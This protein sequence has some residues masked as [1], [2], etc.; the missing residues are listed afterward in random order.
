VLHIGLNK[1]G[2][3]S[4]QR[5][6]G[7]NRREL[8][9]RGF[10][11]PAITEGTVPQNLHRLG[12]GVRIDRFWEE[13]AIEI[14]AVPQDGST[15]ILSAE[16]CARALRDP[17]EVAALH[18]R[19]ADHFTNIRI[20]LYLRRQDQHAA[21]MFAQ[22][23]RTGHVA[24]PDLAAIGES[25]APLHDYNALLT[26]WAAVFGEAAMIPRIYARDCLPGGDVVRDFLELCGLDP[27][28]VAERS[29]L[30]TNPSMNLEGQVFLLGI[31][32]WLQLQ[33]GGAR[34]EPTEWAT[35]S[36]VA[37]RCCPGRGWRPDRAEA[38]AYLAEFADSN[39]AVRRRWFPERAT[40][41]D[42]DMSG[43]PDTPLV[44]APHPAPETMYAAIMDLLGA[45]QERTKATGKKKK[46][47]E[48]TANRSAATRE[49]RRARRAALAQKRALAPP[50]AG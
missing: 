16:Q 36:A 33:S 25:M 27:A 31:R 30:Q 9:D 42:P 20:V 44:L 6:L 38:A 47:K 26:K 32:R 8:R 48:K 13:L 24:P 21:S 41:F 43:L 1:T 34:I 15:V 11:Y 17:A 40:L 2:S 49:E 45:A 22:R 4:I 23:L 14:A 19:L 50:P 7:T 3:T 35:L 29:D 39:E 5:V 18:A 12:P 46:K 10:Y 37:T 28:W